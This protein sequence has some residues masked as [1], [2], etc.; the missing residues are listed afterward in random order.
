MIQERLYGELAG[1]QGL[2]ETAVRKRVSRGL[3]TLRSR[4]QEDHER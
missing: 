3:A 4:L 1:E 2:T